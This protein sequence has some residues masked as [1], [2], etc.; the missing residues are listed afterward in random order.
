MLR[1]IKEIFI[2]MFLLVL[3]IVVAGI[4]FYDHLPTHKIVPDKVEY[5]LPENL[6]G[7]LDKTLAE[8]E[9]QEVIRTLTVSGDDLDAYEYKGQYN[10]GKIDPFAEISKDATE[11]GKNENGESSNSGNGQLTETTPGK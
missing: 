3:I 7:E 6:Q 8:D 1:A 9:Q 10:P 2:Y 5:T 4:L 11:D